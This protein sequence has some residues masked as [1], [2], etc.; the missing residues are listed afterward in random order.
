[1][2][3]VW[4]AVTLG[5]LG[6]KGCP[7]AWGGATAIQKDV[8]V[9][10]RVADWWRGTIS[11][12]YALSAAIR[13]AGLRIAYAPGALVP[14]VDRTT[15]RQ[16][17]GWTRRQLTI[18]RVYRPR[19]WWLGLTAHLFYCGG[20]AASIVASVKGYRLAEWALIAQLS[21]GMLK[22][23]NRATLAKAALPEL[24][25]W[26]RRHS[27]VHAIWVPLATWIWLIALVSSTFGNTVNWRGRRYRIRHQSAV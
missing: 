14:S 23:L 1:M 5:L 16:F 7:F 3:G 24:E 20:M 12:D 25:P 26:F 17:F 19:L 2:R 11:D 9:D 18:T 6:P 8:F 21:P 27:W 4:D 15:A 22:G 10:A 13:A